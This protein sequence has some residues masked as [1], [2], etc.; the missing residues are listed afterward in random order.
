MI[1]KIGFSI[2][3]VATPVYADISVLILIFQNVT[4]DSVPI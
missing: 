4:F 1:G 2:A 3:V